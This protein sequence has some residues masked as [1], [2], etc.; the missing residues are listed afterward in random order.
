MGYAEG[1]T[2][3][4][5]AEDAALEEKEYIKD[6]WEEAIDLNYLRNAAP[7]KYPKWSNLSRLDS[8]MEAYGDWVLY[9]NTTNGKFYKEYTS[10]G[11]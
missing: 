2:H 7:E 5:T 6:A 10:I 11:D 9:I 3:G 4:Y 1:N 8:K